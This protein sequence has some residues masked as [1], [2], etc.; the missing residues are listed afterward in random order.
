MG[1]PD[2]TPALPPF[3]LLEACERR[4]HPS[5]FLRSNIVERRLLL[6]DAPLNISLDVVERPLLCEGTYRRHGQHQHHASR[7]D[8]QAFH[9]LC[10]L[11][12]NRS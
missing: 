2:V 12:R 1:E 3:I 6:G 10:S 4:E 9:T 5:H 8:Q 11:L 7:G